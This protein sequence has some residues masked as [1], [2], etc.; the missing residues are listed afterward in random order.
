MTTNMAISLLL[1]I[2]A[3]IAAGWIGVALLVVGVV[4]GAALAM[5]AEAKAEESE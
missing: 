5:E 2:L 3:V 4:W 1:G